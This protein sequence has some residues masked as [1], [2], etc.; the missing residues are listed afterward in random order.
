MSAKRPSGSSSS[1]KSKGPHKSIRDLIESLYNHR[2]STLTDLCRVERVAISS[3]SELP[4]FRAA[5][6]AAWDHYVMSNQFLIELRGLTRSYPLCADIVYDAQARVHG[7]PTSSRSWN[8]AW[9]VLRKMKDEK[10]SGLIGSFAAAEAQKQEMWGDA[11]PTAA[12]ISQLAACF[13]LEWTSAVDTMLR[14]WHVPP[15]WY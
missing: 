5:L 6:T 9:L 15:V 2:Y 10:N 11:E 3:P 13:E 4:P 8:L 1:K 12:D 7:D 14:H